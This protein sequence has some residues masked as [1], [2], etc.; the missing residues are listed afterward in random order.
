MLTGGVFDTCPG[1]D[2]VTGSQCGF[3]LVSRCRSASRLIASVFLIRFRRDGGAGVVNFFNST[4]RSVCSRNM[5]GLGGC[6]RLKL[7]KRIRGMRGEQGPEL[8]CRLTGELQASNVVRRTSV[9]RGTPG[10]S[11]K[12]IVSNSVEFVCATASLSGLSTIG[13][14]LN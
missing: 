11:G 4:V 3:V 14:V 1:L 5:N 13:S 8:V 9:S 12:A 2:S 10:V 6:L 7:I